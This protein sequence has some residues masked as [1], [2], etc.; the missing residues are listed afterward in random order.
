MQTKWT[1]HKRCK[2]SH[3]FKP[4]QIC[5]KNL[6]QFFLQ[7]L[8]NNRNKFLIDYLFI[9]PSLMFDLYRRRPRPWAQAARASSFFCCMPF[10]ETKIALWPFFPKDGTLNNLRTVRVPL[11]VIRRRCTHHTELGFVNMPWLCWRSNWPTREL[12][13]SSF[14]TVWK[15]WPK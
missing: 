11:P 8:V 5:Y 7:V 10:Q 14:A 13:D 12:F 1:V 9:V 3:Y 6:K 4:L 15:N 2:P